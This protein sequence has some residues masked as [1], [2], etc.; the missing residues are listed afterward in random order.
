MFQDNYVAQ[1]SHGRCPG[2]LSWAFFPHSSRPG[3][4][5]C[6]AV[7]NSSCPDN[8]CLVW[9]SCVESC[10]RRCSLGRAPWINDLFRFKAVG[11]AALAATF[12]NALNE[13]QTHT[14][15]QKRT[16]C[17]NE[18]SATLG[19]H[20]NMAAVNDQANGI[21]TDGGTGSSAAVMYFVYVFATSNLLW[22]FLAHSCS[23]WSH[24][25]KCWQEW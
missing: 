11:S 13:Q 10:R 5:S 20:V 3:K 16:P 22:N 23:W 1:R 24:V 17:N 21:L 25:Q 14:P 2:Q 7:P 18:S 6:A 4:I 15:S 9:A 12:I 8:W 19:L